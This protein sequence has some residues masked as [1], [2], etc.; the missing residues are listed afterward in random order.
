[1]AFKMKGHTLPGIKQ[2]KSNDL[3]DGRSGSAAFQQSD[4]K[5]INLYGPLVEEDKKKSSGGPFDQGYI[6]NPDY[7]KDSSK[8]MNVEDYEAYG[9]T[10]KPATIEPKEEIIPQVVLHKKKSKK[11][12][13]SK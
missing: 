3:D 4:D 10:G 8:F 7:Y 1:M 11:D 9:S 5:K 12:D 6:R 2:R 13:K